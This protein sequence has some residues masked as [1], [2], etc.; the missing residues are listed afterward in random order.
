M[1]RLTAMLVS[2]C[3]VIW[4]VARAQPPQAAAFEVASVRLSETSAPRTPFSMSVTNTRVDIV[5]MSVGPV[6]RM[7]F[8]VKEY[9]LIAPAWLN[10]IRV[11][12]HA[13]LP[14]RATRQQVPEMLQRLLSERFGLITHRESRIM[15]A[16]SLIVD[17]GGVKMRQVE[18]VDEL[19]KPFRTPE[20][21]SAPTDVLS[22]TVDG[23]VR[24]ISTPGATR[25]ITNRTKYDRRL[26]EHL[27]QV[28]DA[29]RMTMA[30]LAPILEATI[31][32]PV[33]DKTGLTGVYQFR[34]EL[35]QGQSTV[36]TLLARGTTRTSQGFPLIELR[37][38]E[39]SKVVA[40]LGLRLERTRAPIEFVVV[41]EMNRAPTP[42]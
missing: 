18:P 14:E 36:R 10:Q 38:D 23:P 25:T 29:T 17:P 12:I 41:D 15:N 20:T 4:S 19:D 37:P 21:T 26:T 39:W 28:I 34:L 33:F 5:N 32:E 30:E 13:T 22:E 6:L 16:Y 40:P 9:Q 35:P 42:N 7:A 27:G 11:H 3:C 24:T 31:D 1:G 2:V 8:R